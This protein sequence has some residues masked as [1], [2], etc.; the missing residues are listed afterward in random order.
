[1]H[2]RPRFGRVVIGT[3][4]LAL[5]IGLAPTASAAGTSEITLVTVLD[6]PRGFCVDMTGSK[7]SAQPNS[8]LQTHTCYDYEGQI[9]VDQGVTTSGVAKGS[10]RFPAFGVCIVGTGVSAGSPVTLTPCGETGLAAVKMSKSG[11]IKPIASASL[12][13][14]AGTTTMQGGGGSPVHL[15]RGLAWQPCNA[16][17]STL[18]RWRLKS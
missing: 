15:K 3:A 17:S 9:A 5:T 11:Q 7:E 6:E 2:I 14:T 10:V 16:G 13:L 8:P 12:C 1:M 18:Q 4:T